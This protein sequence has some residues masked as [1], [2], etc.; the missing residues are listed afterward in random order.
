MWDYVFFLLENTFKYDGEYD[1]YDYDK[2][3][4]YHF[5]GAE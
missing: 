5:L 4:G 1:Y 2:G 3:Y